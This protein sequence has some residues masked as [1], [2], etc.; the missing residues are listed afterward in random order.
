VNTAELQAIREA[1]LIVDAPT[2][3]ALLMRWRNQAAVMTDD[4]TLLR[5]TDAALGSQP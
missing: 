1:Q 5:E 2:L 4:Y 3:K